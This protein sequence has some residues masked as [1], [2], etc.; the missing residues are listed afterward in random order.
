[1]ET[2]KQ[3]AEALLRSG[4]TVQLPPTGWSMYPTIV[5]G[6]DQAVI[7]PAEGHAPRRGD[8]LLYRRDGGILVLHRV[9]RVRPQGLYLV[10]DNQHQIEGPLRPDQVRGIMTA[11]VRKG[12]TI[13]VTALRYR[14]PTGLWL[15]LRPLRRPVSLTVAAVKRLLRRGR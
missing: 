2:G 1:M 6:R 14:L 4:S 12:R 11:L 3:D 5:P 7:A 9:W 13:P 15:L 8:V 10:G